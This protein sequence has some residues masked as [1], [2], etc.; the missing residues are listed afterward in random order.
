MIF[1]FAVSG[2]APASGSEL[3][4]FLSREKNLIYDY[5]E[6]ANR[7]QSSILRKSWISPIM[8]NYSEISS[9]QPWNGDVTDR[10]FSIGIDQPI[11]K[12]GGIIYAVKFANV[13]ENA[14]R[15]EIELQRRRMIVSA[16]SILFDLRKARLQKEQLALLVRND[17]IDIRRKREQYDAG[18]IDSSFLDQA[19]IQRNRDQTRLLATELSERTLRNSFSLLSDLD[20]DTLK[21][22][23]L[24]LIDENEYRALNRELEI[25]RLRVQQNE[26][27]SKMTW[28]KYLP[29]FSLTANYYATD[30]GQPIPGMDDDYYRY[31]FRISMPLNINAPEDIES[32]RV[33]YLRSAVELQDEKKKVDNEYRLVLDTIRIIDKK[34]ELARSDERLYRSLLKST[35]E[36]VAAGEKTRLDTE[37]MRN[38]MKMA[39]LDAMIYAIEKQI[40]LLKL[41]EKIHR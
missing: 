40:Q 4:N 17:N 20:P 2:M 39:R 6:E 7:L 34:I 18:I 29:V 35:R 32:S 14:T 11:F 31:G 38:S 21:L 8:L 26:Y 12:S 41:Y 36:Q 30:Y 25:R 27:N 22:P 10:T 3:E 23:K 13:K 9:T 5:E 19:I 15:A 24:T 1:C 28:A 37:I 16:I 33:E